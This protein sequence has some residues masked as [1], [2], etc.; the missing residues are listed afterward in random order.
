MKSFMV[1]RDS[2]GGKVRYPGRLKAQGQGGNRRERRRDTRRVDR[3]PSFGERF[4]CAGA[5]LCG[6]SE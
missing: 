2:A 6:A 1:I 5:R 4:G 3:A